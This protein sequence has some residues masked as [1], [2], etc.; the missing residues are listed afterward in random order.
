MP[1]APTK[2]P[3]PVPVPVPV[4]D[5]APFETIVERLEAIV[6]T[7]EKGDLP[8]EKSLEVFE[9]GVRLSRLGGQ[10]LDAAE[11]KIEELLSSE[12]TAELPEKP[13][14]G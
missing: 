10:R 8:L 11:A 14:K 6:E 3:V 13:H 5:D 1:D 2:K 7:L 4:N 12:E 9:E